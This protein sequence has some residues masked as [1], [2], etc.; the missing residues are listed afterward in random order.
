MKGSVGESRGGETGKPSLDGESSHLSLQ[1]Y[2]FLK[3]LVNKRKY[4]KYS[5]NI[6]TIL[7]E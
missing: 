1:K 2:V 4:G 7:Q 3:L 6:I 5:Y